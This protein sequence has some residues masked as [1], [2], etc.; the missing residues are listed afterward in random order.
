VSPVMKAR[1]SGL[2]IIAKPLFVRLSTL[3]IE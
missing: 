2:V 1:Q 3:K